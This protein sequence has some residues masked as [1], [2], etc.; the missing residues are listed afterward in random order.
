MGSGRGGR[1]VRPSALGQYQQQGSH[2]PY[3]AACCLQDKVQPTNAS[4]LENIQCHMGSSP[5]HPDPALTPSPVFQEKKQDPLT[6]PQAGWASRGQGQGWV[7]TY[8]ELPPFSRFKSQAE[9]P[10][11]RQ[12]HHVLAC[13]RLHLTSDLWFWLHRTA[14]TTMRPKN[15]HVGLLALSPVCRT[16]LS[17]KWATL[18]SLK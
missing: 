7:G 10:A 6:G 3:L 14:R 17:P 18:C 16:A 2:C 9:W 15:S 4:I 5:P 11:F 8:G 12:L 1:A 13:R